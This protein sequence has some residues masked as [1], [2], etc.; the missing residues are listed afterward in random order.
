MTVTV[1]REEREMFDRIY[2]VCAN[3]PLSV[4][5]C[6]AIAKRAVKL[7]KELVSERAEYFDKGFIDG[8]VSADNFYN[9]E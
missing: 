6:D 1:N 7:A 5:E 3:V 2:G 4:S 8:E 9:P